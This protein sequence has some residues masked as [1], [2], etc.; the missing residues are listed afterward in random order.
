MVYFI[1]PA[2]GPYSIHLADLAIHSQWLH[3]AGGQELLTMRIRELWAHHLTGDLLQVSVLDYFISFPSMHAAL[4]IFAIWFLRPWKRMSILLTMIYLGLL[5]P[6]LV[7]LEWHY[8]IDIVGG[9]ALALLS[10]WLS[11]RL[12]KPEARVVAQA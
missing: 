5:L 10:I 12:S 11:E 1:L 3:S 2:K 8:V 4:P 7:F 9:M 6:A